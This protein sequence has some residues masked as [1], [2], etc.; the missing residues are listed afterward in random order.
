MLPKKLHLEQIERFHNKLKEIDSAIDKCG[1][2][3][4]LKDYKTKLAFRYFLLSK[5]WMKI[6][7]LIEMEIKNTLDSLED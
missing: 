4:D 7:N 6:D 1:D 2:R 3:E 5:L